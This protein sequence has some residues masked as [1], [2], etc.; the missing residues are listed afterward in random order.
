MS[1][2]VIVDT[3]I[4]CSVLRVPNKGQH[5]TE[6]IAE[7]GRLIRDGHTLLLPLA[8]IYET[9]NHIAQNGDGQTRRRVA[10]SFVSQVQQAF[11]GE[12]PW[13]PT[14][15]PLNEEFVQWI[16]EF[17][18][19]AMRGTGIGDLS[20]VKVWEQQCELHQGRRVRV[21]SYDRHLAGFDRE[22]RI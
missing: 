22:P 3:S 1:D 2:I 21:W 8:T 12:A 7:L 18:D 16:T 17:P 14:P 19:Y 5:H 15:L 13:T 9:G 11:A 20:I 4:L 6:A 10:H